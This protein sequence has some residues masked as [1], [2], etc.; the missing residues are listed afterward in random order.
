MLIFRSYHLKKI[1]D[2]FIN[3]REQ[4]ILRSTSNHKQS[5]FDLEEFH[6][7]MHFLIEN[8]LF[9]ILFLDMDLIEKKILFES[10]FKQFYG[11]KLG[12]NKPLALV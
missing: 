1:E 9:G 4:M 2:S 11:I 7:N 10:K 3:L 8:Y 12:H 5:S 6:K